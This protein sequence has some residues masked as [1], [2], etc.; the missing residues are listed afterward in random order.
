M[1]EALLNIFEKVVHEKRKKKTD[2]QKLLKQKFVENA[3]RFSFLDPFAGEF[4][5]AEQKIT[6]LGHVS[7]EDLV[8]GVVAVVNEMARDLGLQSTLIVNLDSWLEEYADE[9]EVYDVSF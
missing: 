3:E 7:D 8:D 1:M 5:Y 6:L 9:L 4:E 2:F